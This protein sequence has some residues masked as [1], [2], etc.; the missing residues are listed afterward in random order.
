MTTRDCDFSTMSAPSV[1]RHL[2][3]RLPACLIIS[4]LFFCAYFCQPAN[5][6]TGPARS[7][8]DATVSGKITL[9]GKPAAGVVI[10]LRSS[11]PAQ[12]DS[13]FKA[14]TDPEGKYRITGVPEGA[15][16]IAPAAPA[17]V[18]SNVSNSEGQTLIIHKGDNVEGIDFDLIRGG[19]ITGKITDANG[20]PIVE[21]G[22]S[23]LLADYSRSGSASHVPVSF[24]TDDRGV[25]RI[26]G[27]RPGRYKVYVGAESVYRGVGRGRRSLPITFYPDTHEAAKAA[28]ID[29]GEASEA[30]R[31]DITLGRALE[32]FAV[33]G[34]VVD[35][36]TGKPVSNVAI[37]LSKIMI[38]DANSTSGY[39]G[40]TNVRSNMDGAFRLEKLDAGKYSVSIQ[41]LPESD[42]RAE[43]VTVDVIDQDVTGLLIKTATGASLSGT[44]VLEGNRGSNTV[45][46][47]GPSWIS[48][49]LRNESAGLTSSQSVQIK[50]DGSFR[51]S[52]LVAGN[53]TFS[54][55]SWGPTGNAKPITI[56]RVERDGVVQPNGVQ[57][58]T[59]EHLSGIR[60]VA[61]YSS[62]SIRG[63]VKVENG[64]LPPGGFLGITL[65]KV[66]E[67]NTPSG[68]GTRVDAR[69]H[70]LIEGLA[71]GT[72]ELTVVAYIPERRQ[73]PR[74]TKQLV[75]VSD[76]AATDVMVTIDLTPPPSP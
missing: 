15:F 10:G 76:G 63:V 2:V 57:V 9:K 5:S 61:A 38:I 46:A 48:T 60:I 55:G 17:F 26:F 42:L 12:F 69:G 67:A 25:Y 19:V 29:I 72:Y 8:S 47:Q 52:G 31:I 64:T 39:G 62:G 74:T 23:L 75:T 43:P 3:M 7:D 45:A 6:Q 4:L 40:V 65:S 30:T 50:P 44:V 59:G 41:P 22:V 49:Y 11:E 21:E 54:V 51:I 56:S 35:A 16:L 73:R 32:G 68:G 1:E 18:I 66:G 13:P 20:L 24:Q 33:S 27:I 36:E 71:A 70:F 28:V 14:T 37:S 34:R 58:Q 53:V